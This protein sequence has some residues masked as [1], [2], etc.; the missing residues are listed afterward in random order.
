MR[1][2]RA[3]ERPAVPAAGAAYSAA[4]LAPGTHERRDLYAVTL[5]PGRPTA[6]SR[7]CAAPSSTSS[8][9]RAR[10]WSARTAPSS[11]CGPATTAPSPATSPTAT[12]PSSP[13][14]GSRS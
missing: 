7:T 6:P 2:V 11:S 14:P 13:A 8:S 3:G 5:E 12:R 4:L 10:R 9:P 1:V